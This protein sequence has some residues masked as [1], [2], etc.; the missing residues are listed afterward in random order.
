MRYHMCLNA[1][2]VPLRRINSFAERNPLKFSITVTAVK[3]SLADLMIQTLVE[4]SDKVNWTRNSVFFFFGG[5]YQGCAQYFMY[6]KL[7]EGLWPGQSIKHVVI[8]VALSNIISDPVF[9]FPTFYT[10]KEILNT[11]DASLSTVKTAL[12]RYRENYWQDWL[13]SWGVW[14]PGYT[15]AYAF[16]PPHLRMACVA[17]ISFGY[18]C[19]LSYTRGEYPDDSEKELQSQLEE[20]DEQKRLT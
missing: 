14:I 11:G 4:R 16:C 3:A 19:L 1:M 15:C 8:K 13:N 17:G 12:G 6:A 20:T 10:M 5:G 7:Y 2:K 9:F 18:V